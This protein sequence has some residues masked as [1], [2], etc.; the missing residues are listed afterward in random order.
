MSKICKECKGTGWSRLDDAFD[1]QCLCTKATYL[2]IAPRIQETLMVKA[3]KT[4]KKATKKIAKELEAAGCDV[5]QDRGYYT[6]DKV[7]EPCACM[8]PPPA[9]YDEVLRKAVTT[10]E[11]KVRNLEAKVIRLEKAKG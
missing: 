4:T 7:K 3:S 9:S 11:A 1:I 2:R 8:E 6:L 5:C 10:L